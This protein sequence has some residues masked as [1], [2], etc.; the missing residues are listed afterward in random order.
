M[1]PLD[2]PV[3]L[4]NLNPGYV[5]NDMPTIRLPADRR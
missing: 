3:V 5:Q 4:L 2:A 1:G